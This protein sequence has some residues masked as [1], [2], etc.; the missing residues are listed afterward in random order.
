MLFSKL[1]MST[2]FIIFH[3]V[4]FSFITDFVL[5]TE[6]VVSFTFIQNVRAKSRE[7]G[8]MGSFNIILIVMHN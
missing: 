6:R 8:V 2:S 5:Q 3:L 4:Y 7:P 1:N